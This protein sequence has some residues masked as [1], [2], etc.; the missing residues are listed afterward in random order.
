MPPRYGL[1]N[2]V[3][4]SYVRSAAADVVLVPVAILYDQVPEVAD[5]VAEARGATK[6][7]E[8]AS[9][10][11]KYVS[12]LHNPF[13]RIHVRFGEGV[14]LAEAL[15]DA[16][17]LHGHQQLAVLVVFADHARPLRWQGRG[18]RRRPAPRRC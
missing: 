5:Y 12:G 10:F 1:L 3:V 11:M 4:D 6:R 16:F 7:P 2:Y 17:G 8:S 18:R 15:G 14:S 9:W 13:G